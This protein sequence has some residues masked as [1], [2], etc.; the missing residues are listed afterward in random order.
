MTLSSVLAR[1]AETGIEV[2]LGVDGQPRACPHVVGL[3]VPPD[4]VASLIVHRDALIE[5]CREEGG[6]SLYGWT[7]IRPRYLAAAIAEGG[8]A[9]LADAWP[10]TAAVGLDPA[11][12]PLPD[13]AHPIDRTI[14]GAP[15]PEG[16]V[17]RSG[18]RP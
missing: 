3:A 11:A 18:R 13:E 15:L 9:V 10:Y 6:H 2:L 8:L 1:L 17:V 14:T 7:A 16:A 4:L 12:V 5:I